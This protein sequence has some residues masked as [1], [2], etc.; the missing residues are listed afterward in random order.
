MNNNRPS[1]NIFYND[2]QYV[3]EKSMMNEYIETS[4]QSIFYHFIDRKSSSTYD[5]YGESTSD[6]MKIEKTVELRCLFEVINREKNYRNEEGLYHEDVYLTARIMEDELNN[7]G[8]S[9][10]AGDYCSI[11]DG[12]NYLTFEIDDPNMINTESR[13]TKGYRPFLRT[14]KAHLV[15]DDELKIEIKP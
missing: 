3:F 6:N 9:I 8:V 12:A 2:E 13:Y 1:G 10:I 4:N 15:N 11:F 5:I 7:M 14:I